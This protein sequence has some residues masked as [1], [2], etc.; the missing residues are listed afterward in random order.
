V[1]P[2]VSTPSVSPGCPDGEQVAEQV[3][4][5]S[6]P[7]GSLDGGV[8][9]DV[10]HTLLEVL[11]SHERLAYRHRLWLVLNIE[12]ERNR[13]GGIPRG[14]YLAGQATGVSW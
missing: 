5:H 10:K 3:M 8:G 7:F 1:P 4:D 6:E 2:H 9:A 11:A 13:G 14:V 12:G